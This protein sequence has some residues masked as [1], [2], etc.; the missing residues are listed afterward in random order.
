MR[1]SWNKAVRI[2]HSLYY[3]NLLVFV[4]LLES[5]ESCCELFQDFIG[6]AFWG[7]FPPYHSDHPVRINQESVALG[8]ENLFSKDLLWLP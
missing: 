7:D 3:V 6:V 5:L 2:F 8:A 4:V 1:H